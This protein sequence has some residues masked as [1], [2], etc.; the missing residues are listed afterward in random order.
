MKN[1]NLAEK[2]TKLCK[3]ILTSWEPLPT[4]LSLIPPQ[5]GT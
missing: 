4:D 2:M 5:T 3:K 1:E